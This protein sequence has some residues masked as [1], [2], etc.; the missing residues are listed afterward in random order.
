META[1]RDSSASNSLARYGDSLRW[2]AYNGPE[3]HGLRLTRASGARSGMSR[4][5]QE[6]KVLI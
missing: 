3:P 5:Q 6:K 2:L 1:M 4:K